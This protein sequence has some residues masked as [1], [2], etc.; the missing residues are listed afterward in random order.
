MY[1]SHQFSEP[2]MHDVIIVG[3]GPSGCSAAYD[4]QKYGMKVL[5]LDKCKFPRIKPCGGGLTQKTIDALRYKIEPVIKSKN[6]RI[7]IGKGYQNSMLFKSENI[8]C[9]MTVRSEFDEFCLNKVIESGVSFEIIDTIESV[10]EKATSVEIKTKDCTYQAKYLIGADGANSTIR[11]LTNQFS[12]VSKGL[13]IEGKVYM[14]KSKLPDMEFDFGVIDKGYGWLFPKDN[15][16]N[17]GLYSGNLKTKFSK[18][19][20]IEY[21]QKK[22]GHVKVDH[23]VGQYVGLNGKHYSQ[24]SERVFLIGDAAGLVDPFLAEGIFNA[25][26]SGQLA[27][28]AIHVGMNQGLS[29][30]Q[31]YNE[32]L[33]PLK[34]DLVKLERIGIWFYRF[35]G[36]FY[37][38]LSF[39]P[40]WSFLKKRIK[41]R[42]AKTTNLHV[43][44]T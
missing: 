41:Q 42:K 33:R 10:S 37:K 35:P 13:A 34:A 36:L 38:G 30:K 21:A 31:D 6:H 12:S 23:I 7:V 43:D 20:V 27:A 28:K 19:T 4:L 16:V 39:I 8:L 9:T 22:L 15:H 44:E 11:K 5:L 1:P 24:N 32:S 17:V 40:T 2:T 18:S 25:I 29:A 26:I 14:E 3:A